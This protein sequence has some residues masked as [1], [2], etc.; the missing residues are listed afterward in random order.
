MCVCTRTHTHTCVHASDWRG[1]AKT[2]IQL[3]PQVETSIH[4]QTPFFIAVIIIALYFGKVISTW[5]AYSAF[6]DS[7]KLI[8]WWQIYRLHNWKNYW[9]HKSETSS[10][11]RTRGETWYIFENLE[12]KRR[13]HRAWKISIMIFEACSL[14]TAFHPLPVSPFLSLSLTHTHPHQRATFPE[15][16]QFRTKQPDGKDIPLGH[17]KNRTDCLPV[18]FWLHPSLTFPFRQKS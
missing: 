12:L 7:G 13:I 14:C 17:V 1:K 10:E 8:N 11:S 9:T 5:E 2:P 15:Q 4:F 6:S 18:P 3:I 16:P